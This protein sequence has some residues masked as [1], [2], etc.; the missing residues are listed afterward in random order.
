MPA[1][2]LFSHPKVLSH[3]FSNPLYFSASVLLITTERGREK[4]RLINCKLHKSREQ[5]CSFTNVHIVDTSLIV[6]EG[7][8]KESCKNAASNHKMADCRGLSYRAFFNQTCRY[9]QD[10]YTSVHPLPLTTHLSSGCMAAWLRACS[11][12]PLLGAVGTAR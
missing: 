11:V 12:S 4:Q 8:S 10:P 6:V 9:F 3:F 1:T 5:S 2:N 7:R